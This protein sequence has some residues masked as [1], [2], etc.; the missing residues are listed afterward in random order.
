MLRPRGGCRWAAWELPCALVPVP[1][2]CE[3]QGRC[4]RAVLSHS[5]PSPWCGWAVPGW[6]HPAPCLGCRLWPPSSPA[7]EAEKRPGLGQR[8]PKGAEKQNSFGKTTFASLCPS[9]H[10]LT[11]LLKCR[12]GCRQVVNHPWTLWNNGLLP[13]VR[14][15]GLF[16]L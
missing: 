7:P 2:A 1:A 12:G 15:S 8:G 10:L 5:I 11:P 13:L 6:W 16:V 14:H 3:P 4:P 9:F